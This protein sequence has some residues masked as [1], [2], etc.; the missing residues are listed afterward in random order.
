MM[1]KQLI[2]RLSNTNMKNK[3]TWLVLTFLVGFFTFTCFAYTT[4]QRIRIGGP[5]DLA[6]VSDKDLLANTVAPSLYVVESYLSTLWMDSSES[7]EEVVEAIAR[8]RRFKE[9]YE[10]S[11]KNWSAELPDGEAKA[12]LTGD[13][14]RSAEA[15]FAT[16]ENELVPAMR[17]PSLAARQVVAAK[18]KKLF[19]EHEKPVQLLTNAASKNLVADEAAG[20][21]A[22]ASGLKELTLIGIAA[23]AVVLAISLSLRRSISKTE[24]VLLDNAGKLAALDRNQGQ[25]E[26]N[27]DGSVHHANENFLKM[28]GLASSEVVGRHFSSF[29]TDHDRNQSWSKE[30]W[31]KLARGESVSGDYQRIGQGGKE[32]WLRSSYNPIVNAKGQVYK[33]VEFATEVT[34]ELQQVADYRGQIAS[35]G[36]SQAVIEFSLDGTILNANSNFLE[37]VGYAFDEIRGR[38]HSMFVDE[39]SRQSI[40][41][42][43]FWER[44]NRGETVS[45]EFCRQ[46][47]GGRSI[48]LQA[49][50]NPIFDL[51]GRVYKVVKYAIDTTPVVKAREDLKTKVERILEVVDAAAHGDLTQSLAITGDDPIGQLA[52]QLNLLFNNFRTNMATIADNA[53]A[54]AGAS[55]ELSAVSAQM[56]ASAE[57]TA[58][59]A[60]VVSTATEEV[61]ANVTTVATGV[62][63]MNA[64]IR[65]IAKNAAEAARVSSTAVSV[66]NHTNQTIEKLG[67]SSLEIG[68]VVNVIT[69]IAEQTNL[70]ALNATIEAARAG[71]AGKGFAVVANEVKELAK[72]TA[73]AT[74][75]I[76]HKIETIQHDTQ[77]AVEAIRQISDVIN[78]ISDISNTIASA[79]EEQ[80]ATANEMGRNVAEAARGSNEISQN[81]L[82]VANAATST[83][84]GAGNTQQ[85]AGE[86]SRMA[87]DLQRLVGQFKFHQDSVERHNARPIVAP[88]SYNPYR[89]GSYVAN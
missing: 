25:V 80:T 79:V 72:E 45:G 42:R 66:A 26:Y 54:L 77:G 33:V 63:E 11:L 8:Y 28:L 38:H 5:L 31:S 61:N 75:D 4:L 41:Y 74:E 86:L 43:D 88:A 9:A 30:L 16:V 15:I 85:S 10:A 76:S 29:L 53:T 57:E 24:A 20:E 58:S 64:A 46:G 40:Q 19:I 1:L 87:S 69:S 34:A 7:K 32:V 84:Q 50:Y 89:G 44:L 83:T 18:L 27:L 12:L 52:T 62:D 56:S 23:I 82:A 49:S 81:I 59:Q 39:A 21:R 78:Q 70:L 2:S 17:D 73:R 6:V 67:E 47:K 60:S 35:I 68:K 36:K 55:E 37:T 65:E 22:V 14:K 51:N 3:V 48:W 71:E 13:V